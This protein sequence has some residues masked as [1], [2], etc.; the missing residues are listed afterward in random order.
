M[1]LA[2]LKPIVTDKIIR[3]C[4]PGSQLP[5]RPSQ[6]PP[7]NLASVMP[8][9]NHNG[10][11]IPQIGPN[12]NSPANALSVQRRDLFEDYDQCPPQVSDYLSFGNLQNDEMAWENLELDVLD[13]PRRSHRSS[14]DDAVSA[15]FIL[16]SL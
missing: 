8:S 2:G 3:G 10:H 1:L 12:M 15:Y 6:V 14:R 5:P 13:K 4:D 9:G 11:T 16:N 7:L